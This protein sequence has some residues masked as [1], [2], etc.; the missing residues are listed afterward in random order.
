MVTRSMRL[1]AR[2]NGYSLSEKS[3]T[4]RVADDLKGSSLPLQI[5]TEEDVFHA[6]GLEYRAPEERNV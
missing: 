1:L 2:K 4:V 3:L 5:E 6:L